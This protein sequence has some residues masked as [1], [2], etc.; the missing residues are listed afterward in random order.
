MFSLSTRELDLVQLKADLAEPVCGAA[1]I[2][3]GWVR[4]HHQGREVRK[5]EY[6]AHPVLA[7]EEGGKIFSEALDR[8]PVSLAIGVHRVGVLEIG[9]LAVW[10]GVS[11][12]HRQAAFQCCQFLIDEIKQR[13]PIWKK[14]Y[15]QEGD[16]VWVNAA[17]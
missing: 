10:L 12:P 11:A 8:F 16:Y 13:V 4:N 1:V 6:Q 7:E 2:F 15:Y 5:L 17:G 14:E 3:E 9:D